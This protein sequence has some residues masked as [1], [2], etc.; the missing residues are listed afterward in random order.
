MSKPFI[1]LIC[2]TDT[3]LEACKKFIETQYGSCLYKAGEF[4]LV[5]FDN[6]FIVIQKLS[7]MGTLGASEAVSDT[8]VRYRPICVVGV[9]I[10]AGNLVGR[11]TQQI[12]DI[13]VGTESVYYEPS[14]V[15]PKTEEWRPHRFISSL[16][17]DLL[18]NFQPPQK[19][20][21]EN[22]VPPHEETPQP[23]VLRGTYACG[24]RVIDN[25]KAVR[26]LMAKWVK[27]Y[28]K[29]FAAIDMESAGIAS[30]CS[31]FYTK[32]FVAKAISDFAQKKSDLWQKCAATVSISATMQWIKS[33][34]PEQINKLWIPFCDNLQPD[35]FNKARQIAR[36]AGRALPPLGIRLKEVEDRRVDDLVTKYDSELELLFENVL[37]KND[38]FFV[39]EEHPELRADKVKINESKGWIV[40]PVDG[41]QNLVAGR[42]EVAISIAYYNHGEPEFGII[43]MPYRNLTIS[44]LHHRP[45]EANG[46]EWA[47]EKPRIQQLSDAV[48]ALPGDFRRLISEAGEAFPEGPRRQE[49]QEMEAERLGKLVKYISTKAASIRITGALAYDLG[50]LALGEVD[51]RIS[52]SAKLVD[53]AA[54]VCLIR[55]LGGK[56]TDLQ[57]NDWKPSATTIL[58]AASERLHGEL[59]DCCKSIF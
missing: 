37:R 31:Q 3:E 49:R 2:A 10:C 19:G 46:I 30:A 15:L 5:E 42:P 16:P 40:D 18:N 43:E 56:V 14:K 20:F 21:F 25:D 1:A 53:V 23:N 28:G 57:G 54:G 44:T 32:F 55:S 4:S 22:Q 35:S 12:C 11:K 8:I 39:G 36:I 27:E 52:T 13:V 26:E 47:I 38:E 6:L 59:L 9:G 33:L 29:P 58:A 48:V 17:T 50:C 51:A 7:R 45:I 34:T 41:T 24:E